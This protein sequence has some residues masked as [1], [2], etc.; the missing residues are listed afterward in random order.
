AECLYRRAD[1]INRGFS[2]YNT[3][4]SLNV[5]PMILPK[6]QPDDQ[7]AS[8]MIG[9]PESIELLVIFLGANDAAIPPSG[10]H[11]PLARYRDN[12]KSLV[13]LVQSPMS[14]YYA[15][16][17][18]VLLVTPPP[19]DE[20]AWAK[21]CAK[22][23]RQLDRRAAT[24]QKYAEACVK[25]ANELKVPVLDLHTLILEKAGAK[26]TTP[27]GDYLSDGL[28]L[29]P[30]GNRVLF[31]GII[32]VIKRAWPALDPATMPAMLPNYSSLA[33]NNSD[34]VRML[35]A[36]ASGEEISALTKGKH[37]AETEEDETVSQS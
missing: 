21:Q 17:T 27:L 30:L 1:I 9:R 12:L 33:A 25:L 3:E 29:G 5:L 22:E 18:R 6:T 36:H 20:S 16:N 35:H 8:L 24:T 31:E 15:K 23:G 11:V 34:A 28:H 2:G 10:Q 7:P 19:L 32:G 26:Q 14:R 37:R 13:D 4:W